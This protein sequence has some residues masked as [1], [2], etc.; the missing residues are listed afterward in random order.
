MGAVDPDQPADRSPLQPLTYLPTG[1][2]GHCIGRPLTLM[3]AAAATI[4]PD[5]TAGDG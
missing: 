3:V 5:T 2:T 1:L 4:L